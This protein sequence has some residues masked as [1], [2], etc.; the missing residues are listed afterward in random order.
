[1][2]VLV[3]RTEPGASET[4]A[5]LRALG[6]APILSPSAEIV[7]GKA[8]P[9][10]K[11]VAALAFTSAHGARAFARLSPERDLPVFAVGAASAAAARRAG[12]K[13]VQS[14]DGDGAALAQAITRAGPLAGDVLHARGADQAFD[15]VAA[16]NR[17]GVSARA[18][19]LYRAEPAKAFT[20]EAAAAL[21]AGELEAALIHSAQGA[22]RLIA[23][24]DRSG[25]RAALARLR[26]A[27]ISHAAAAP[28]KAAGHSPIAVA[29]RPGE[30][31]LM[32]ALGRLSP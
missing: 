1:M 24:A 31:Q 16:L 14:A 30:T 21:D 19:I 32:E 8:P 9:D 7:Y 25:R 13:E 23:L 26:V 4:A 11:G 6:H 10:L 29:E 3:T 27:A 28:F 12:F 22:S 2:K 17:D 20:G 15:L 5:R 18:A